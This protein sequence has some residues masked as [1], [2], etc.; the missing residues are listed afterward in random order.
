MTGQWLWDRDEKRPVKFMGIV[1]SIDP[2]NPDAPALFQIEGL[3]PDSI[4]AFPFNH[5][6]F[7]SP[8]FTELYD[9]EGNILW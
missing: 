2:E 8:R 7:W 3:T 9:K 6:S 1:L 5:W 4:V